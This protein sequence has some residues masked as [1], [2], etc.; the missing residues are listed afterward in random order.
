MSDFVQK[1]LLVITTNFWPEVSGTAVY[2]TD[3]VT[4]VFPQNAEITVLTAL[5][6]YQWFANTE[7][8]ED[9]SFLR[10]VSGLTQILRVPL[11]ISK[12]K[13]ATTRALLE[14][15]FW[16]NAR[17]KIRELEAIDFD[18]IIAI[19]PT[20]SAGLVA[21]RFAR[22]RR[23]PG[24][25]IFQDL[26]SA[27]A[28]QSGLPGGRSLA[29][30]AK[31]LESR[32]SSWAKY[33]GVIS[34]AMV[35]PVKKLT[36]NKIPIEVIYNYTIAKFPHYEKDHA[37]EQF[38]FHRDDFI[39]MHT[40]NIGFKQD[41]INVVNTAKL[42]TQ[43]PDL[44]IYI[45]G[46]GN[47]EEDVRLAIRELDNI[48][49]L[50]SVSVEQYPALLAAADLLLVNERPSQMEMSL[51]SKLT[52]YLAANRPVI[53]AVPIGGATNRYLEGLADIVQAGDPQALANGIIVLRDNF[54]RRAELANNGLLFA[55]EHLSAEKGRANYR[56]WVN[57]LFE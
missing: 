52:S 35:V 47:Q 14:Y 23:I 4:R 25:V 55:E 24:L 38:S 18:A 46:H 13:N 50:P 37:R 34:P 33:I 11:K 12:Q 49:L 1:R 16:K 31:F 26:S 41:L 3:L 15:S 54:E 10:S 32:A 40:G 21:R 6:H 42:L 53:A 43:E 9:F 17:N 56:N 19:L 8:P 2:A 36:K 7:V 5:P 22:K 48:F 51:P 45:V 44:K 20:V 30:I 57:R 27:G 29:A 28:I 39:V